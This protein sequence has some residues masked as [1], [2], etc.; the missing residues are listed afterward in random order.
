MKEP[1][2]YNMTNIAIEVV[3]CIMGQQ[4]MWVTSL[5]RSCATNKAK[6]QE[7]LLI[8][9]DPIKWTKNRNK[10]G[11]VHNLYTTFYIFYI[12]EIVDYPSI[13]TW[14]V[15][16][17]LFYTQLSIVNIYIYIM[18]NNSIWYN[19]RTSAFHSTEKNIVLTK[20]TDISIIQSRAHLAEF[21]PILNT[22]NDF[23]IVN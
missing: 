16:N 18:L 9:S 22:K 5:S 13:G 2:K 10:E 3:F 23:N 12:I 15:W 8:H 20:K 1:R 21:Y 11:I 7:D 4:R 6:H 17:F 14:K 19:T